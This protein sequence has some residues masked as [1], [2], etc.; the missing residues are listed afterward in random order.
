MEGIQVIARAAAILREVGAQPDGLSL[1]KLANATGLARSTVQRI[2]DA[3]E[4]EHLVQAGAGGV[5][6]GW[7][8]RRLGELP[9]SGIAQEFRAALYQLFEATHETVDLSTLSGSEVLF[10]D[11]FLSDQ[12]ERAVPTLGGIYPAYTMA[13]GKALLACLSNDAIVQLYAD[14]PLQG[15]TENSITS[16][17]ELLRQI[18]GIRAGDFAYDL[19]EHALGRSAVGLP[20]GVHKNV[21]LAISVVLPGQRFERQRAIVEAAL[22]S[23]A[24]RCRD[25]LNMM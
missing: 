2:V 23:C 1:G 18:E 15:L 9:G 22:R 16:M 6:P 21:P 17:D 14:A 19:E 7:G 11:R 25:R 4:T 24:E 13:T 10:M 12:A 5:R 3:L 8:L 20:I